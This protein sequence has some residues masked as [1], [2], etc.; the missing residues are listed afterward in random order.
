MDEVLLMQRR[1]LLL[2]LLIFL[3]VVGSCHKPDH[4]VLIYA[5]KGDIKIEVDSVIRWPE[6]ATFTIRVRTTNYTNKKVALVFDTI[7]NVYKHQVENLYITR[8]EDTFNLGIMISGMPLILNEKTITSFNCLG[9]FHYGKGNFKSFKEI[10]SGFKEGKMVYRLGN[11]T[12]NQSQLEELHIEADTLLLPTLL[13]VKTE[14]ALLV[15]DFLQ[16]SFE[17]I[18]ETKL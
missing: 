7:S 5:P 15:N 2:F 4:K 11:K 6:L 14:K 16:K 8:G 1:N 3:L 9:Y 18:R 10:E 17:P 12:I 13:E